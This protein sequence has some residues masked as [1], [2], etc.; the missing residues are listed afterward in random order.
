MGFLDSLA[1]VL[2]SLAVDKIVSGS[3]TV[4]LLQS[5]IPSR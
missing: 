4:L 1:G 3:L 2:Q 5:A